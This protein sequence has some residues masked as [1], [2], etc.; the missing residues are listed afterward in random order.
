MGEDEAQEG[1]LEEARLEFG[2]RMSELWSSRAER[3]GLVRHGKQWKQKCEGRGRG[4]PGGGPQE[5]DLP[6]GK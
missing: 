4:G 5:R 2:G 1:L 3:G 6:G